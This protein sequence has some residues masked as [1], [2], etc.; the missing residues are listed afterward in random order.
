MRGLSQRVQMR[1]VVMSH[2]IRQESAHGEPK[3]SKFTRR[4]ETCDASF[5]GLAYG[6]TGLVGVW[7]SCMNWYCS[8]ECCPQKL[9]AKLAQP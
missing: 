5:I 1:G 2:P 4:C 3:P 8:V 7:S 9:R 6:K